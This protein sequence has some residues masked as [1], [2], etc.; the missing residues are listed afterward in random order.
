MFASIFQLIVFPLKLQSLNTAAFTVFLFQIYLR[1][2]AKSLNVPILSI[3]YALAPE[4]P[5]PR[6]MEE[7][8]FAYIWALQNFDRLGTTGKHIALVGDSAGTSVYNNL[9]LLIYCIW[10]HGRLYRIETG[11]NLKRWGSR[12]D[13]IKLSICYISRKPKLE[14]EKT[15]SRRFER[16]PFVMQETYRRRTFA[17]NVEKYEIEPKCFIQSNLY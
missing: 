4:L 17:R 9:W 14:T 3:N 13:R 7:C 12:V 8:L 16:R 2:W 15:T 11:D 6:A 10:A 1:S 5:F